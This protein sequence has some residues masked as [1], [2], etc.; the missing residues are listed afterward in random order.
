MRCESHDR[1]ELESSIVQQLASLPCA[2]PILLHSVVTSVRSSAWRMTAT[3]DSVFRIYPNAALM[4]HMTEGNASASVAALL[5]AMPYRRQR[6]VTI[7]ALDLRSELESIGGEYPE[8][9]TLVGNL[10]SRWRQLTKHRFWFSHEGDRLLAFDGDLHLLDIS[11]PFDPVPVAERDILGGLANDALIRGDEILAVS[12]DQGF[13][14]LQTA[15][16]GFERR[17]RYLRGTSVDRVDEHDGLVAIL[18][19]RECVLLRVTEPIVPVFARHT[20]LANPLAFDLEGSFAYLAMEPPGFE[21]VDI[22]DPANPERVGALSGSLWGFD[23]E[24]IA[25]R[26]YLATIFGVRVIDISDRREPR[27]IGSLPDTVAGSEPLAAGDGTLAVQTG[28]QTIRLYETDP[29]GDATRLGEIVFDSDI[30]SSLIDRGRLFV[31]TD[32]GLEIFAVDTPSDPVLLGTTGLFV[33]GGAIAVDGDRVYTVGQISGDSGYLFELDISDPANAVEIARRYFS[34]RPLSVSAYR[35]RVWIANN[36]SEIVA[37]EPG[38]LERDIGAQ[39][40][41]R[42]ESIAIQNGFLYNIELEIY[43][44]G[45]C[46]PCPVDFAPPDGVLD[47]ADLLAFVDLFL[48]G[49]SGSDLDRD[50]LLDLSD[51]VFF[52]E[53]SIAGCS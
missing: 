10:T 44:I 50:G 52:V 17:G 21:I 3:F 29:R 6:N 40:T 47:S 37:L 9:N 11:D 27:V 4:V 12:I 1:A 45:D 32:G 34:R 41:F 18:G 33:N 7:R 13:E 23:V 15:A 46:P 43:G 31:T 8:L 5:S 14:I 51:L 2:A 48:A 16:P 28:L 39:S 20:A 30:S 24:A 38:S 42:G 49:R 25:D 22:A 35:D 36:D 19:R 26:A 53:A